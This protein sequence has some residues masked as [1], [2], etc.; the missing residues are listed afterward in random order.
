[1][2]IPSN[3]KLVLESGT[4]VNNGTIDNGGTIIGGGEISGGA[5]TGN[6]IQYPY[7]DEDGSSKFTT[8]TVTVI[9]GA[10][11][12]FNDG[13]YI[14]KGTV[15]LSGL[16]VNATSEGA[17][18]IL[19][20]GC[21]FTVNGGIN[22]ESGKSLTIYGQSGGTG[23]LTATGGSSGQAGIGG[24]TGG[25]AGGEVTINGGT[26]T[27]TGG[28]G[29]AA[30]IGGGDQ[31]GFGGTV[32]ING[33]TVT[34]TG[35]WDGT[36]IGSGAYGAGGNLT[37]TGGT[38]TANGDGG[39]AGIGSGAYGAGGEITISGG[40]VTANGGDYGGAGIGDG[41][42]DITSA[43]VF[44]SSVTAATS[45]TNA[46]LVIG[47]TTE[48]YDAGGSV[49]GAGAVTLNGDYVIPSGRTI[50]VP[51]DKTLDLADGSLTVNGT[52]ED[53]GNGSIIGEGTLTNNGSVAISLA[54]VTDNNESYTY[55]GGAIIPD[56]TV[57]I[58]GTTLIND[59]DYGISASSN[60]DVGTA[61]YTIT[62]LG[63]FTVTKNGSFTIGMATPEILTQPA[64]A[65]IYNGMPLS[66]SNLS[67]G[68]ANV[69]GTFTWTTGAYV[70]AASG[71]YSVTFTP[72]DAANYKTALGTAHVTVI[73]LDVAGLLT[74]IETAKT[75]ITGA[76]YGDKNGD[77][78]ETAKINLTAVIG[79]A[80]TTAS[81]IGIP[82]ADITEA[83][84]ILDTAIAT[85]DAA[86]IVVNF[87]GLKAKIDEAN[88]ISRG[89]YTAATW[90]TLKDAIADAEA[91]LGGYVT[92]TEADDMTEA[93]AGAIGGLIGAGGSG[94]GNTGNPTNPANP[95]NPPPSIPGGGTVTAPADNPPVSNPDGSVTLPGGGAVETPRG[96][97][98]TVPEGSVVTPDGSISFPQGSGGGAVELPGGYTLN[99]PENA[100]VIIDENAPL[101]YSVEIENPFKDL[102]QNDWFYGDAMFAYSH[103]LL[104]GTGAEEYSPGMP[105][106][107]GMVVAVLHRLESEPDAST[108]N[109][110]SDV[111]NEE[112][113]TK[114]VT[115]A[116]GEGIVEGY[117]DEIFRPDFDITRQ[118]LAAVLLR[119]ANHKGLKLPAVRE[120]TAFAD[121]TNISG[122]AREAVE[123]LYEA[124][125]ISGKPGN[126]FDPKGTATRAEA[127]AIL[128]R[129]LEAAGK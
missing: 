80:T 119:L 104:N 126:I 118:E 65:D 3:I 17:R 78:P 51:D 62:G 77:Y 20:D 89:N 41:T 87:A 25:G 85:F 100:V 16:T 38:V 56:L 123:T 69:P 40:T 18:L 22:V 2:T 58:A 83:A 68:A 98:V 112:Y 37:I 125:I 99:L 12:I 42:I 64:A 79:A 114:A 8:G 95:T 73:V 63:H 29:G 127:A 23:K 21:D 76:T 96:V 74:L 86:K 66:S 55:N 70:P 105:T 124:G 121:D 72:N 113:Y 30:G 46:I 106:T 91:T 33:G 13:W 4:I 24:S 15:S 108:E 128:H 107:R 47:G 82:Q 27:A 32:T 49:T 48:F 117:G 120:Y 88:A 67:G 11:D 109:M 39:G 129:F 5:I 50:I 102:A 101:G 110:F 6:A 60:T 71:D 10:T 90:T 34:A 35:G 115:W 75:K 28:N 52:L 93:L 26:I 19:A 14:V 94:G 53:E 81:A 59:T 43:I 44:A 84:D 1:L 103:G 54:S 92:Q 97:T 122:Y 7:I 61:S 36:G 9:T 116:A 45:S 31:G 57:Q 111:A